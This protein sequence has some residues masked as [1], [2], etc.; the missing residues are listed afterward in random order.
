MADRRRTG[1]EALVSTCRTCRTSLS[2]PTEARTTHGSLCPNCWTLIQKLREGPTPSEQAK[3]TRQSVS[4][5]EGATQAPATTAA[6][7]PST[8]APTLNP[9]GGQQGAN[10][11]AQNRKRKCWRRFWRRQARLALEQERAR[12]AEESRAALEEEAKARRSV[13]KARQARERAWQAVC[14]EVD[15]QSEARAEAARQEEK[16]ALDRRARVAAV[17]KFEARAGRANR[18]E[19]SEAGAAADTATR[20]AASVPPPRRRDRSRPRDRRPKPSFIL[21]RREAHAVRQLEIDAEREAHTRAWGARREAEHERAHEILVAESERAL[22]RRAELN[23][24]PLTPPCH[25]AKAAR[26]FRCGLVAAEAVDVADESRL[27]GFTAGSLDAGADNEEMPGAGACSDGECPL[28]EQLP[29]ATTLEADSRSEDLVD[30]A[31]RAPSLLEDPGSAPPEP[32]QCCTE[33]VQAP[34]GR[35][36]NDAG[37]K[38]PSETKEANGAARALSPPGPSTDAPALFDAAAS[39]RTRA[40]GTQ[41]TSYSSSARETQR[42]DSTSMSC[43]G[44]LGAHGHEALKGDETVPPATCEGVAALPDA[45]AMCAGGRSPARPTSAMLRQ[46]GSARQPEISTSGDRVTPALPG[47]EQ[48]VDP[49]GAPLEAT[50]GAAKLTLSP[51]PQVLHISIVLPDGG[52][53]PLTASSCAPIS[54]ILA[55]IAAKIGA[56][57]RQIRLSHQHKGLQPQHTLDTYNVQENES[58]FALFQNTGGSTCL[59]SAAPKARTSQTPMAVAATAPAASRKQCSSPKSPAP[60]P[61]LTTPWPVARPTGFSSSCLTRSKARNPH[62]NASLSGDRPHE[63]GSGLSLSPHARIGSAQPAAPK[64]KSPDEPYDPFTAVISQ[65]QRSPSP[66]TEQ[67]QPHTRAQAAAAARTPRATNSG[68]STLASCFPDASQLLS[69]RS[70]SSPSRP[71][72]RPPQALGKQSPLQKGTLRTGDPRAHT[73]VLSLDQT[74]HQGTFLQQASTASRSGN[75]KQDEPKDK[76]PTNALTAHECIPEHAAGGSPGPLGSRTSHS[77]CAAEPPR[78]ACMPSRK[79]LENLK[80]TEL[81][82]ARTTQARHD[83]RSSEGGASVGSSSASTAFAGSTASTHNARTHDEVFVVKRILAQRMTN[84]GTPNYKVHWEGYGEEDCTWEPLANL[85]GTAEKALSLFNSTQPRGARTSSSS[86]SVPSPASVT[87]S[88]A[89]HAG[90]DQDPHERSGRGNHADSGDDSPFLNEPEQ[91][92]HAPEHIGARLSHNGSNRPFREQQRKARDQHAPGRGPAPSPGDEKDEPEPALADPLKQYRPMLDEIARRKLPED[93]HWTEGVEKTSDLNFLLKLASTAGRSWTNVPPSARNY[94]ITAVRPLLQT[95]QGALRTN[96]EN[97][98]HE[99]LLAFYALPQFALAKHSGTPD[100]RS[101]RGNLLK[102]IEGAVPKPQ[103]S[104]NGAPDKQVQQETDFLSPKQREAVKTAVRLVQQGFYKRALQALERCGQQGVLDPTPEIV[105]KMER[106]H[107]KHTWE[108][109]PGVPEH[110]PTGLPLASSTFKKGVRAITNGSAPDWAGWTAELI[111]VLARD[112]DCRA[113]LKELVCL[114]RDGTLPERAR[115]NMLASWLIVLPKADNGCRPIAGGTVL[116]KLAVSCGMITCDKAVRAIFEEHGLQFGVGLPDGCLTASRLTQLVL[117]SEPKHIALKLDIENAFNTT[118]RRAFLHQLFAHAS[119]TP[120]FRLLYFVYSRPSLLIV[121]SRTGTVV[122]VLRS[123]E[124]FRQGCRAGSFGFALTTHSTLTTLNKEFPLVNIVAILDDVTLSGSEKEVF[125]AFE[126]FKDLLAE[127]ELGL[128]LNKRKCCVLLGSEGLTTLICAKKWQHRL[129]HTKGALELLGTAVGRD[130]L[131]IERFVEDKFRSW[132]PALDLLLASDMP[133]QIALLLARSLGCL[134]PVY[135]LRSLPPDLTLTATE[136]LDRKVKATIEKKLDISFDDEFSS[137]MFEAPF[138]QGGLAL[139]PLSKMRVAA[140][141]ASTYQT[142]KAS[143]KGTAVR[144]LPRNKFEKLPTMLKVELALRTLSPEQLEAATWPSPCTLNAFISKAKHDKDTKRSELQSKLQGVLT[145]SAWSVMYESGTQEQKAHLNARLNPFASCALRP[146][147]SLLTEQYRITDCQTQFLAAHAAM[148]NPRNTPDVCACDQVLNPTHMLCC[149][150]GSS[151]WLHRHNT[152]QH[153]V[154]GLARK[155]GLSV[156][157]NVRKSF[158]D[159]QL[160][161]KHLEPDL[162]IYF[163]EQPLWTDI[164]VT[165]ATAPSMVRNNN[166]EV[167]DAM[168]I[169]ASTK[170]AKYWSKARSRGAEFLPLVVETHGRFHSSFTTLLKKLAGQRN[171]QL[172]GYHGLTSREMAVLIN[173][174][175]VRGNAAHAAKVRSRAWKAQYK[176]KLLQR[177]LLE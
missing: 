12:H 122:A 119:M 88:R 125:Q 132:E 109:L 102:I 30:P 77:S 22:L 26:C 10:R 65:E 13:K 37:T 152:I 54:S 19:T 155:Q 25:P 100:S 147:R 47:S 8:T 69:P 129:S 101:I 33:R 75:L 115:D 32:C 51:G 73:A 175:L 24:T 20:G 42:E 60:S 44:P 85:R 167:G 151:A 18:Q 126:R 72:T 50:A 83:K 97:L 78:R 104:S 27:G 29:Q 160:K 98:V 143:K 74:T 3:L 6:P 95:L 4:S 28:W 139:A 166:I 39:P 31:P 9:R 63:E 80:D 156:E 142:V 128:K 91:E 108:S 163:P 177:N 105:A 133:A 2:R 48:P 76:H 162:I 59:R 106:L 82:T 1:Q 53:L 38:P 68:P 173:L 49:R 153:T 144:M 114:I 171:G 148:K 131:C 17:A 46:T 158:E 45:E 116:V 127:N 58:I 57:P 154:E 159:A 90:S 5:A 35:C 94:L 140:F 124:G 40:G 168:N 111:A 161:S 150:Y 164:S 134:R 61:P 89:A 87:T 15:A 43:D 113:A 141:L 121:R 169:R 14:R 107:P 176:R 146:A 138:R 120:L 135:D 157:P 99:T 66:G 93:I 103:E 137:L 86:G 52:W 36:A 55:R 174:D 112:D 110:A 118:S 64:S 117:E 172:D 41:P 70:I 23:N 96:N 11:R 92:A 84:S 7:N 136:L 81:G 71:K 21:E 34:G 165:E 16:E 67:Q 145:E 79:A 56:D 149:K 170:N 130:E 62:V 123:R